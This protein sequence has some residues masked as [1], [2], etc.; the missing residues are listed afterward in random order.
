MTTTT[1][2]MCSITVFDCEGPVNEALITGEA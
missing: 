1:V 2:P